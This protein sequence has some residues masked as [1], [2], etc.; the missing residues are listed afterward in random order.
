MSLDVGNPALRITTVIAAEQREAVLNR[1]N[2]AE[3]ANACEELLSAVRARDLR[4]AAVRRWTLRLTAG[5]VVSAA[6]ILAARFVADM[7]RD[8]DALSRS[9]WVAATDNAMPLWLAPGASAELRPNARARVWDSSSDRVRMSLESGFVAAHFSDY[10]GRFQLDAGPYAVT[11]SAAEFFLSWD[12]KDGLLELSVEQG[13]VT[14]ESDG[15][16]THQ[17]VAGQALTL[18]AH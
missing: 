15:S 6:A 18:E 12:S 4:S 11:G 17:I 10:D 14:I 7:G 3:R 13:V 8:P 1:S 5:I 2:S 9:S 16:E